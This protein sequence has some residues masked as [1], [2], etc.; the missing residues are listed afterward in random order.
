MNNE[1]TRIHE[2]Q[3]E[4]TVL[5]NKLSSNSSDIG[6]WKINKIYE[7]R[8]QGKEDPYNFEELCNERQAV[9]DK[10]NVLQ[11]ELASIEAGE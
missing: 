10:I 2:I 5:M 11:E 8:M 1:N 9:R 4:I 7:Y 3:T 6:D